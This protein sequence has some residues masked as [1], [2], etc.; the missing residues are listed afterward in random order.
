MKKFFVA[1]LLLLASSQVF[2]A[3]APNFT[4]E[5][6]DG[7]SVSLSD[8]QGKPIVLHFWATWCP[9]CKKLQPGLVKLHKKYQDQGLELLAIS[10]REDEGAKPQDEL[11]SRGY[12]FL[13]LVEGEQVAEQ[14]YVQGTPTTFFIAKDGEV[15]WV[16]NQSDPNNPKL[17]KA[18]QAII[19]S[20][21]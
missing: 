9:Y 1:C 11:K 5:T 19:A 7:R 20:N 2:A 13:T 8:Y 6:Q 14:Y 16:T 3:K 10:L 18:V 21:K 17:E 15:L 4:L 12:D